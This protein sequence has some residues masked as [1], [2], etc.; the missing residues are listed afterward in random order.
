MMAGDRASV[1]CDPLL[2]GLDALRVGIAVFD[3]EDRLVYCNQHYRYVYR[4]FASL[5]ELLGCSFED[6]LH[7]LLANGEIAVG[8]SR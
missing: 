2:Q 8:H 3:G 5:E 6:I 7:L 1:N 4:S